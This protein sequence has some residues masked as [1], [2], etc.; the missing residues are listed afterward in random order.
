MKAIAVLL[1]G[2]LALAG[3]APTGSGG[4]DDGHSP[5]SRAQGQPASPTIGQPAQAAAAAL[6]FAAHSDPELGVV[7]G[8][9]TLPP[10]VQRGEQPID[11]VHGLATPC[12][13]PPPR[14]FTP[15]ERAIIQAAFQGRTVH[16]IGDP[17]AHAKQPGA[18][19]LLLAVSPPLLRGRHGTVMVVRCVPHAQQHLVT[20]SWDGH[21]WQALATG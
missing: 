14:P 1:V 12:D 5:A 7:D 10:A 4:G 13:Q 21:A 6:A 18:L 9:A 16:F 3:C 17:A 8:Y 19:L 2:V 15:A 20:V 11:L